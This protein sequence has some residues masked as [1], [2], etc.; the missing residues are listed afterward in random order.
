[1]NLMKKNVLKLVLLSGV[2]MLSCDLAETPRDTASADAI[3]GNE[4]GLQ[5]YIHDL[6]DWMPSANDIIRVDYV[7]D[8]GA[9]RDVPPLARGGVSPTTTDDTSQSGWNR[10]SLG[11][12]T[13]WGWSTL[14]DINYFL[15]NNVGS[16]V[17][18]EIRRHYNGLARFFRAYFYFEKVKRFGDVPWI[19]EPLDI[20]DE[21]LFGGR[22]DRALV[23]DNVLA[24]INFAIDNIRTETDGSRTLITKDVALALKSRIALFEGTFRKYHTDGLASG[25]GNTADNWL[26]EA[27]DAAQQI[28]QRGNFSIYTGSGDLSYQELFL[29]DSPN[30]AEDILVNQLDGSIGVRHSAN[31]ILNSAT[32]GV[33]FTLV[34]PFIHTYL[35]TDGTPFTSQSGYETMTFPEE[36]EN[37]DNRLYQTIRTPYYESPRDGDQRLQMP[38]W[39]YTYTGYQPSKWSEPDKA[40]G[41]GTVNTNT[42]QIFRYAEVLLNYAE[43]KA[44]LGTITDADWANTIGTLRAR[45][46]ITGGLN[47][48]PETADPYLQSYYFSDIS[49]PVI[50]EIRRERGIELVMEGHR[51]YDLVRWKKGDLMERLWRGVYV[52]Q[53]N[54]YYDLNNDGNPDI[55]FYTQ[56]PGSRQDGVFYLNVASEYR[57][58]D[59]DSGE[60]TWRSEVNKNWQDHYY[61]YPIP[62]SDLLTNP[63]LV[64][65]PGW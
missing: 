12:D 38:D 60:L 55:Y 22:D 14:R 29:S 44:E 54:E 4:Q 33:R 9:R 25:L 56:D 53:A 62:E 57:L 36:I 43:A 10:V 21:R 5:I 65:N 40:L 52:P 30:G 8:Y 46:G 3:F 18:E 13:H 32:T 19:D 39:A 63:N 58:T 31:W 50:L 24:D 2:I 7:S 37:R 17:P 28:M 1:M 49:D 45:A 16:G 42:V 51:F 15:E 41:E 59:G 61:L 11:G 23:M 48:L 27:A 20:E 35:N 26:Q 6:Y 47:S 64:Q 34:R